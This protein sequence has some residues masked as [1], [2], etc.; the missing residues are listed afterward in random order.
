MQQL[1]AL[2]AWGAHLPTAGLYLFIFGWLFLESTGFPIS[3]EPL[4]LL[5]GSYAASG[6]LQILLVIT[7]A[8]T[9]KVAASCLAFWL[10]HHINL[11]RLARPDVPPDRGLWRWL[12]YVRPTKSIVIAAEARIRRQGAWGVFLGRLVPIVRSFISYPAGALR[13][14]FPVFFTA[15][16]AGSLLWIGGWTIAGLVLGAS[17]QR[18]VGKLG[19][20]SFVLLVIAVAAL[21]GAW[22]WNHR[23]AAAAASRQQAQ[24]GHISA[25]PP[26]NKSVV[27]VLPVR[28][29][30]SPASKTRKS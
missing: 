6:K 26:G 30:R 29:G 12:Y 7:I 1:A 10:G 25:K 27:T 18:A 19:T 24:P 2:Y 3:D 11:E 16:T 23:R 21:A 9:G 17:Y 20:V 4:L 5:A 22:L 8:L 14:R 28:A 15:T 13:M